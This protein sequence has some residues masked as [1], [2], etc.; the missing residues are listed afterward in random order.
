MKTKEKGHTFLNDETAS[1]HAKRLRRK[2]INQ[3]NHS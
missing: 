1:Q 2:L 3:G